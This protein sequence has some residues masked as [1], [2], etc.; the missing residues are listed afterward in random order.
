M[1]INSVDMAGP[2]AGSSVTVKAPVKAADSIQAAPLSRGNTDVSPAQVKKMVKEM[3]S[4]LDSMNIS[5]RYF[6][7]GAHDSKIAIKVVNKET[8]AVIRE[9][10]PKEMQ[11]LQEKMSELC[12]MI[13]NENG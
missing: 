6:F 3:Q 2:T 9:I 13:F 11:S 10:P 1:N 5:L 8:G 4:Y 12:G 7:Y